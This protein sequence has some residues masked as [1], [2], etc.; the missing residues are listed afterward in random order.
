MQIPHCCHP[1]L[2]SRAALT[3]LLG[4]LDGCHNAAD[5]GDPLACRQTYEFGNTGCFEIAGHVVGARGQGLE[6]ILVSTRPPSGPD[7]A[8]NS[9]Y[10]T[11]DSTGRFRIRAARMLGQPPANG[12]PDTLSVYVF[13]VDI[14]GLGVGVP[15]TIRDSVLTVV[16]VAPVGTAPQVAGVHITLPIP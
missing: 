14:R 3:V 12:A 5:D 8:F 1:P 4:V 16:T 6:A 9:G 13:A 10:P 11:T 7:A 15:A 2:I